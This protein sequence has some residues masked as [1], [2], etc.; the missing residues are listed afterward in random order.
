MAN[1]TSKDTTG[2]D[3]GALLE[4]HA[5][6]NR[7]LRQLKK[8]LP[9]AFETARAAAIGEIRSS[10]DA[11]LADVPAA[12]R[13]AVESVDLGPVVD[14]GAAVKDLITEALVASALGED[15]VADA[16]ARVAEIGLTGDRIDL[17]APVTSNST[18]APE[19]RRAAVAA[20]AVTAKVPE[21]AIPG[22]IEAADRIEALDDEALDSLE[23]DKVMSGRAAARLGVAATVHNLAGDAGDLAASVVAKADGL[24]QL[25]GLEASDW[26]KLIEKSG[27]RPPEE[28]K[29]DEWAQEI[30]DRMAQLRPTAALFE[31]LMPGG[32]DPFA[33]RIAALDKEGRERVARAFPG[34]GLQEA[35][36]KPG[37]AKQR[38]NR[39]ATRLRPLDR[40]RELNPELDLTELD[41]S[42]GSDDVKKLK[43]TGLKAADKRAAVQTLATMQRV[44][45]LAP[46]DAP[47]LILAGYNGT[48]ALATDG[49]D[50]VAERTELPR[51]RAEAI[52]RRARARADDVI[53]SMGTIVDIAKGGFDEIEMSNLAPD[54]EDQL[55]QFASYSDMFGSQAYCNCE[56]C[57]SILSPAAYFVDLMC[58]IEEHITDP[59]FASRPDHPLNLRSRR[60]DLWTLPLTCE[61]TNTLVPTLEIIN[62]ILESAIARFHSATVSLTNRPAV[63]DLVYR[64]HLAVD[65]DSFGQPFVLPLVQIDAMLDLLEVPRAAIARRL[66]RPV[67]DVTAAALRLS[68]VEVQVTTAPA[69]TQTAVK[70]VYNVDFDFTGS[71]IAPFDA[72]LLLGPMGVKRDELS[73]LIATRFVA[74]GAIQIVGEKSDDDSVQNDIERMHGLTTNRADRLHRFTR[75]W[76][77]GGWTIN[78]L[79]LAL[80]QL[81]AGDLTAPVLA[82]L[83]QLRDIQAILAT[84]FEETLALVGQLPQRGIGGRASLFD[85]TFNLPAFTQVG[86]V[87]P[88][89]GTKFIHPSLRTTPSDVDEAMMHRLAAGMGISDEDLLHL[90]EGLQTALGANITATNQDDRGFNL[91]AANLST[92]Y[93]HARLAVLLDIDIPDL[94]RLLRLVGVTGARVKNAAEVESLRD[95]QAWL[96]TSGRTLD[97]LAVITGGT[98]EDPNRYP[99]PAATATA[100]LEDLARDRLLEFADTVLAFVP[101]VTEAQSRQV[102]AANPARIE[103]VP[104]GTNFRLARG[105]DETLPV[106]VPA[107]ITAAEPELR[108]ALVE[109]HISKVLPNRLSLRLSLPAD[110]T[111]ALLDL[112]G[113]DLNA[114]TLWDALWGVGGDG[115]LRSVVEDLTPLAVLL[116][117]E[118]FDPATIAFVGAHPALFGTTSAG[119]LDTAA[120][121]RVDAYR[122]LLASLSETRA[123]DDPLDPADVRAV[124]AAHT[125]ANGFAAADPA[126][127]GRVLGVDAAIG[128][129]A[130]ARITLPAGAIDA[131]RTFLVA[132]RTAA[133]LGVSVETLANIV[134]TDYAKLSAAAAALNGALHVRFPTANDWTRNVEPVEDRIRG[135]RRD[136]L[137]DTLLFSVTPEF[138][139]RTALYQH[140]L[141]DVELEGCARTTRVAAAISSAQ[142]YVH[143]CRMNLEQDRRSPGDPKHAHVVPSLV[144][145]GEWTW[146]RNYR[147]WEANRKVFLWPE[148]Y[149]EPELRDDKTPLFR[150]LEDELLQ[151]EIDDQNVL[152]AYATYLRGFEELAHLRIAGAFHQADAT[153]DI[154]HLFAAAH[155]DPP[156]YYYRT[157]E[158]LRTVTRED[159]RGVVWS[160]WEKIDVQI[161]S[162]GVAPLVLRGRL[163]LFWCGYQTRSFNSVSSGTSTFAGYRHTMSVKFTSLRLD[164]TWTPPQEVNLTTKPNWPFRFEAGVIY[165][166]L[167]ITLVPRF[168]SEPHVE[169]REDYGPKGPNWEWLAA[170]TPEGGE[171][172]PRIVGRNFQLVSGVNLLRGRLRNVGGP[173]LHTPPDTYNFLGSKSAV[174]GERRLYYGTPDLWRTGPNGMAE[175]VLEDRRLPEFAKEWGY[176]PGIQGLYANELATLPHEHELRSV[177]GS[178]GDIIVQADGDAVLVQG[179]G[180][181]GTSWTVRRIGTTLADTLSEKLHTEGVDGLL[182]TDYQLDL[183]ESA[184][185]LTLTS[186][187]ITRAVWNPMALSYTGPYGT[188]YREIFFHVPFLIANHLNS[189]GRYAAAQRWY[190]YIFDPTAEGPPP[191]PRVG[192]S[193]EFGEAATNEWLDAMRDRVWRYRE[194]RKLE[195]PKL[196]D[197]LTDREAL[198]R[199]RKDPFNPHAIARLRLSGYQKAIVM[200]YVDNLLDWGD[201]LFSQ[202]TTE[203]VNEATMFYVMAADI[204]G[205]RP[206][207]LGVCGEGGVQQRDFENIRP[208]VQEGSELL[209]EVETWSLGQVTEHKPDR[210][211]PRRV[212][213]R[214]SASALRRRGDHAGGEENRTAIYDGGS[215]KRTRIAS[216]GD[217]GRARGE[218]L[219]SGHTLEHAGK[220]VLARKNDSWTVGWSLVRQIVPV[221]C[222]PANKDLRDY[223]DR[224]EG[225]LYK[226]RHC[227]DITG[228]RRQLAP[229]APEIDPRLLVR[230]RAA[231]LS[232]EDVLAA[233]AGDLPPYRFQYLIE[234]AKAYAA[235][236]QGFGSALLGALEKRDIE[237]LSRL[238]L[239]QQQNLL[240]LS[241]RSRRMEITIAEQSTAQLERQRAAAQVKLDHYQSLVNTGRTPA[242][243]TQSVAR[244]TASG[245]EGGAAYLR[246][247][248]GILFLVPQ[249]GSPF[250]MKYGGHELGNSVNTWSSVARDLAGVA[251]AIAASA[252]LEAGFERRVQGWDHQRDLAQAEVGQLQVAVASSEL[253]RQI[254]E[255]SLEIHEKSMDQNDEMLELLRRQVLEPWAVHLAVDVAPARLQ[256]GL[257]RRARDGAARRAG[258][259]IRA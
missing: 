36:D 67:D 144:P 44:T 69:T 167:P 45:T 2:T 246:A 215:Y 47:A 79:D 74:G 212:V 232:L 249:I 219:G 21:G 239:V 89:S 134:S 59:T 139:S 253:R 127:L 150:E 49:V 24:D 37:S 176:A 223:W 202:F 96:G 226:I 97:D 57:Q 125:P 88:Q 243:I 91:T 148:N 128:S 255:R 218:K 242:E 209:I 182:D 51:A 154:L 168:D 193:G 66:G 164:G 18:L 142:L 160:P 222:I 206:A 100:V 120:I 129:G 256:G 114:G 190:H 11:Q 208:L 237:E 199:Y 251:E 203:S 197:V 137:V 177:A 60:P 73:Q 143:R 72:Q 3:I 158:N 70:R 149:I 204:L 166:S 146:R 181:D 123:E 228:T 178:I 227:Q 29:A 207:E 157:V 217:E 85:R 5:L 28:H 118:V 205:E 31:R 221:F 83:V 7:P 42:E 124:L 13:A 101:D 192:E 108:A 116:E 54:V 98:P 170:E 230:A 32:V 185:P 81:G 8:K 111:S 64:Q 173:Y 151:K 245:L 135:R 169:P 77:T 191:G 145:P 102:I 14:K 30:A 9:E 152:D 22:L 104:G 63:E 186:P 216:W 41:L 236:V 35:L 40:V 20:V 26:D 95:A 93:R 80:E 165:D 71:A 213:S 15:V 189:Q 155:G 119:A 107:G 234:R 109:H 82:S 201:D 175:L 76:R 252:G 86:P 220:Q 33:R 211:Q 113:V 52:V 12:V 38:A 195:I 179:S 130:A 171:T 257:Q 247:I 39:L 240:K 106:T 140:F 115:P 23:R 198:E 103:P 117:D 248:A 183:H 229:F 162:R 136:A 196:R 244:H 210:E 214:S 4:L 56:H 68:R 78:E 112:A 231:G 46:E 61:N 180:D 48:L 43:L 58:F 122:E 141:I 6:A 99:D 254:A 25:A 187:K 233:T 250:S 188:Y 200:K 159:E 224:V 147:V 17:A 105:F 126:Q 184:L 153:T 259:P 133:E 90:V 238:R 87:L 156:I 65:V 138:D 62:P 194:F 131:L 172:D 225:Q 121:R 1:A 16:V 84:D 241:T 174:A 53:T 110:K 19:L 27:A 75:L 10:V 55:K 34:M 161:S 235:T 258:V 94:F 163:Y 92:L 50:R 132:L